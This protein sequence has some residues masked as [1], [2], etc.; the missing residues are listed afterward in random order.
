MH[1][2]SGR[3]NYND[4]DYFTVVI[5]YVVNTFILKFLKIR[6]ELTGTISK[7][8]QLQRNLTEIFNYDIWIIKYC[9]N[10]G[11]TR[12]S[13]NKLGYFFTLGGKLTANDA[14]QLTQKINTQLTDRFQIQ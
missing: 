13:H 6:F 10:L 12:Y 3:V 5:Y 9:S 14:K 1:S 7:W 2:M 4:H 8:V 11:L